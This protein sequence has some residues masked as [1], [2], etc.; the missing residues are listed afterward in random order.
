MSRN[1][2][3]TEDLS[4]QMDVLR[5]DLARITETMTEMGRAQGRALA[6]DL[7]GRAERAK[8]EG[9]RQAEYLQH[10]AEEMVDEAAEMV[11]RQPAMAL[12]VA[13]GLGFLLGLISRK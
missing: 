6:D 5:A 10:R 4:R 12:G 13:A 11:R 1:E 3:T 9:E 8:A 7:R 2:P